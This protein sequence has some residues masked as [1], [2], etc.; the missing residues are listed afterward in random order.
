MKIREIYELAISMGTDN[1]PRGREE[2]EK[3]LARRSEKFQTLKDDEKEELDQESLSNPYSDTRILYGNP[4]NDVT[5]ALVGVDMEVGE[6]VLADRLSERGKV[7]DI[8]IS[9][10][11]EGKALAALAGVMGI[12][13]EIW[14]KLG[15]P[16]NVG[17]GLMNKRS[18]EVFR[19]IMPVNHNRAV[20]AA[21]L[22]EIPFMCLH[23][24]ADNMVTS[25]L[26]EIMDKKAPETVKDVVD[27][28]K[29]IPE[30]TAAVQQNAGPT[31]VVGS[32]D[33]KAGRVW[34][35][36][37]GG[38]EGPKEAI[39]K[40][41]NAGVGTLVCMHASEKHTK[42]AEEH[43]LNIIIAGHMASDSVGLNLIMDQLEARGMTIVPCSGLIRI[44][45]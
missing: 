17:E 20:D 26:Q 19:A 45:R 3:E 25:F 22:F 42:A 2:V 8:I 16:I 31:I 30:Y 11:P 29:E 37:T 39:E 44:R 33:R 43:N 18:Q 32:N 41:A 36:M 1:D 35:D 4:E 40:L 9:H 38:T 14:K 15:V 5:T 24:P 23:T 12:Q 10:H 34:I 13:P 27:A 6:V 21:R 7:I 28:L